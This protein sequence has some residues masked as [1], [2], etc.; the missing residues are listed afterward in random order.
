MLALRAFLDN[1]RV[2]EPDASAYA[3][4]QARA[5]VQLLHDRGRTDLTYDAAFDL[6]R[7]QRLE[8][9]K[10]GLPNR[11]IL[12]LMRRAPAEALGVVRVEMDSGQLPS[13]QRREI[14]AALAAH[15]PIPSRLILAFLHET[16]TEH[17]RLG[18]RQQA[19]RALLPLAKAHGWSDDDLADRAMPQAGLDASGHLVLPGTGG[20]AARLGADL[21]ILIE[22]AQ[23]RVLAKL[24]AGC[25]EAREALAQLRRDV[26]KIVARQSARLEQAMIKGR[27]WRSND[28]RE[29]LLVHPITGRLCQQLI[30]AALD[31]AH[32]VCTF[33]PT[34]DGCFIDALGEPVDLAGVSG[35]RLVHRWLLDAAQL[36]AWMEHVCDFRI[37]PAF[38]QLQ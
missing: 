14:L 36:H 28:F 11:G 9:P 2:S 3:R 8:R 5:L 6:L 13:A 18:L 26:K 19:R 38:P 10:S 22:D 7:R 12:A 20:A 24:P 30:F 23:G 16:A 4:T 15:G 17:R 27:T 21:T 35:V 33:R 31:D 37:V 29:I 25:A 34:D 1:D 32:V